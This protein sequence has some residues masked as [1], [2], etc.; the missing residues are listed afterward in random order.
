MRDMLTNLVSVLIE[1]KKRDVI[2][3]ASMRPVPL[4]P[5][6][7]PTHFALLPT[8]RRRMHDC[9]YG[10][11]NSYIFFS[12]DTFS[13]D[14]CVLVCSWSFLSCPSCCSH[15]SMSSRIMGSI[16]SKESS[17]DLQNCHDQEQSSIFGHLPG[18]IRN[19]IFVYSLI[20]YEDDSAAYPEDSYWFRPGFKGP[21]RSSSSLLQTCKLAYAE[22]QRVFLEESECAFWFSKSR[23]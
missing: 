18:E 23:P 11:V 12:Q 15:E 10:Y 22:G 16:T 13:S 4:T 9:I 7:S 3:V 1:P 6:S 14:I 5:G 19:Q 20:Q 17:L 21:K 8:S 2:S